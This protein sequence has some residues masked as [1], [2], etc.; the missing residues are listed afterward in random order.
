MLALTD[1]SAPHL[2]KM[3]P[4]KTSQAL[5]S[6]GARKLALKTLMFTGGTI[7]G[8]PAGLLVSGIFQEFFSDLNIQQCAR[9]HLSWFPSPND[10]YTP[11]PEDWRREKT[12]CENA[13]NDWINSEKLL[14]YV[15]DMFSLIAASTSAGWVLWGTRSISAKVGISAVLSRS[16]KFL[17][18]IFPHL[19]KFGGPLDTRNT[20]ILFSPIS[21]PSY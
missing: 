11:P 3:V 16:G 5:G 1:F 4:A 15:P 6:A 10:D 2:K 8:M 21:V 14:Y 12:P 17:K 13:Y 18:R 20:S 19:G 7:L 9:E